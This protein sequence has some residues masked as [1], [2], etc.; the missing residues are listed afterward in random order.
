VPV[1]PLTEGAAAGT[2]LGHVAVEGIVPIDAVVDALYP[3][4][5]TGIAVIP[6]MKFE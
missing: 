2:N 4:I 6:W 3:G 1:Q 5:R